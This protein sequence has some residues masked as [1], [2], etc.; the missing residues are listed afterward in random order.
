[1]MKKFDDSFDVLNSKINQLVIDSA[2]TNTISTFLIKHK[3]KDSLGIYTYLD[4]CIV[5]DT[6]QLKKLRNDNNELG[7]IMTD[8]EHRLLLNPFS[9]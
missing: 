1:M 8:Y 7:N 2:R 9:K 4:S 3:M 6:L 5:S